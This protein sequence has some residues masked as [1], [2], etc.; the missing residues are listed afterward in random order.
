MQQIPEHSRLPLGFA[1]SFF[2]HA[3]LIFGVSFGA[4]ATVDE[5]AQDVARV[6]SED[7]TPNL[8]ARFIANASQDGQGQVRQQLRMESS[9]ISPSVATDVQETQDFLTLEQ[10]ARQSAYQ[11]S[12]LRTTLSIRQQDEDKTQD[13]D[14][15]KNDLE[16]QEARL[17]KEIATL[18]A[19]LSQREQ[20]F[21]T[22]T[23]IETVD[24]NAT[25]HGKAADYL[26]R[27]REHVERIA[28]LNYPQIARTKGIE[29]DVRLLVVIKADGS[30]SN[31]SLLES[32]GHKILDEAAIASVRQSAPYGA[33]DAQMQDIV[34]L[35]IVR[36]WRYGQGIEV[37][38]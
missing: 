30:V 16:A 28:N 22:M 8:E 15:H 29:G 38:I 13:E 9:S 31:I 23:K 35:R 27:F 7:L 20:I 36:T 11:A 26:E 18:E 21:S 37:G 1:T 32:S 34:E 4:G 33:F 14:Q 5:L 2:L 12:Y 25:T 17:R 10:R 3:A 19:Q 24:S 6:L